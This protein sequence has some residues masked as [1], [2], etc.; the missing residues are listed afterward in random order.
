MIRY[1]IEK[2][3]NLTDKQHPKFYPKIVRATTMTFEQVAEL[4]QK[5]T[6]MTQSEVKAFLLALGDAVQHYVTNSCVVEVEGLGIFT[7]T[8]HAKAVDDLGDLTAKTILS[9]SVN[10][11]PTSKMNK[12]FQETKFTKANLNV[13]HL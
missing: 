10:Y 2:R 12:R 11:R 3:I 8:I 9:K 6:T 4:L 7:P 1:T 13:S 5:R